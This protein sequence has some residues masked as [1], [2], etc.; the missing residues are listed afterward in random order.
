MT[1]RLCDYN[2]HVPLGE[3]DDTLVACPACRREAIATAEDIMTAT[4]HELVITVGRVDD[5][6]RRIEALLD[7]AGANG[8]QGARQTGSTL[9]STLLSRLAK[10]S[11]GPREDPFAAAIAASLRGS[12]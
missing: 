12:W 4:L 2:G 5:R 10:G 6:L 1:L 9:L 3:T 7:E 8:K 11:R